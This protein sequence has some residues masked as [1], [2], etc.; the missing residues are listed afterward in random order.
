MK[1]IFETVSNV[2]ERLLF[3]AVTIS[4]VVPVGE[5]FRFLRMQGEGFKGVNWV[6][7]QTVQILVGILLKRAYTPMDLDTTEGSA[8]FLVYLHG[9]GPGSAW[10]AAAKTGDLCH[11]MRPK[12]SLDFRSFRDPVL[13]FGDETSL[14]AAQTLSRCGMG[15][16]TSRFVFEVASKDPADHVLQK[17]GVDNLVIVQR[18]DDGSH[19]H[20]VVER[21][22]EYA[23]TMQSPQWVFTG[24]ARSIQTTRKGLNQAGVPLYKSKVKAY[25]SP[26][27]TGMD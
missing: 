11:V 4:E 19:L 25:W 5:H 10:A 22:A 24:Q 7:G 12:D 26:G 21:L 6:P 9:G 17:L 16:T 18:K 14:A 20:E 3:R 1:T 8:C 13:F 15:A 27:K 23:R 2:V